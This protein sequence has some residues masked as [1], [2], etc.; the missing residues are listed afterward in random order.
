MRHPAAVQGVTRTIGKALLLMLVPMLL[1]GCTTAGMVSVKVAEVALNAMGVKL[2]DGSGRSQKTVNMHLEAAGNLNAGE[3]G[4]GMATVVRVYKLREKNAFL[5]TPNYVFGN[6]E[7]EK[8]ALGNDLADVREL[9]VSPGQTLD[10]EEKVP[11]EANYVGVVALFRVPAAN[12]WRFT[13]ATADAARNGITLGFHGCAMTATSTPPINMA[14]TE[15]A[16]LSPT[17]CR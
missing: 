2:P 7:K 9:V 14:L 4:Q 1:G 16:L 3:G 6:P 11:G 12:R 5:S 10:L 15:S 8:A 13:F 17:R